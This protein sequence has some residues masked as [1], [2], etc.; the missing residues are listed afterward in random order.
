M[1]LGVIARHTRLWGTVLLI[2]HFGHLTDGFATRAVAHLVH[3]IPLRLSERI[4]VSVQGDSLGL[5]G[6]A[7]ALRIRHAGVVSQVRIGAGEF[8][9]LGH[10]GLLQEQVSC[11]C[12]LREPFVRQHLSS[13]LI[14]VPLE[15]EIVNDVFMNTGIGRVVPVTVLAMPVTVM[16]DVVVD[17]RL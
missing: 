1:L 2:D 9:T 7:E 11:L 17:R 8:V 15:A 5:G 14:K 13:L 3:H 4:K 10:L 16:H 6:E 12:Q